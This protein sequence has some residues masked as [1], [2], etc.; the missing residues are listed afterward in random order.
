LEPPTR[1]I[2]SNWTGAYK[3]D[4]EN[5]MEE[6]ITMPTHSV[7]IVVTHSPPYGIGDLTVNGTPAGS[8]A[9]LNKVI[10]CNPALHVFGHI[11]EAA[12]AYVHAKGSSVKTSFANVSSK[13]GGNV[14]TTFIN[15]SSIPWT[16]K[17]IG[18]VVV[19]ISEDTKEILNISRALE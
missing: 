11:H 1:S 15:A 12:G 16:L 6:L 19:D 13:P 4:T 10:T 9:V 3:A 17:P 7:D 8:K 18:P 14:K 2:L 5:E